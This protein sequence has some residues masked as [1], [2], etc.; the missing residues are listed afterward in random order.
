MEAFKLMREL[1]TN[2]EQE[3]IYLPREKGLNLLETTLENDKQISAKCR[4]A[5]V[6]D[7][8]SLTS[9]F[10][11]STQT[12]VQ[13]VNLLD[14][15]LA[16]MKIQPKHLSCIAISCLHIAAKLVEEECNISSSHDLIRISQCKFTISDLNRMEKII[17]EK[18][19]FQ[20]KAVTAFTFLHLY[21]EITLLHTSERKPH[22]SLDKLEVQ[23]K[24]CLCRIVFSKAK[25]SVLALAL[26]AQEIEAI[27]SV[28]MLEISQCIQRHLKIADG[29]LLYWRE[30]VAKCM[31]DY[32]SPECSKPDNKKLVWI[33]S[34]RTAQNLHSSYYSVPELPTIPEGG[35]DESASEDSCEDMSCGEDSLSSD[36]EVPCSPPP[37]HQRTS[38]PHS[39]DDSTHL[40]AACHF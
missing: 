17:S 37:F 21:H 24:A 4:D 28:D 33:L 26:L 11:Y 12:F 39:Q 10:G 22:L 25:P 40:G 29:E 27:Q 9:F 2:F 13:A 1:K 8:W 36:T 38:V 19:N 31:T 3:S 14:R 6:E 20:C 18:L 23:L 35:W 30:L 15:F 32:S 34:R 16:M 7:L 5:K